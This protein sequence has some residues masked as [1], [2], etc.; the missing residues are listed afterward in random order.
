MNCWKKGAV[1]AALIGACLL[2][3]SFETYAV[4]N[5]NSIHLSGRVPGGSIEPFEMLCKDFATLSPEVRL[6]TASWLDGYASPDNGA[7]MFIPGDAKDFLKELSKV[8]AAN[9][10][11]VIN[12]V[13]ETVQYGNSS[14]PVPPRCVYLNTLESETQ[15]GLL[16][17]WA[18][19]YVINGDENAPD[20]INFDELSTVAN[21]IINQC[22]AAPTA[23][24]LELVEKELN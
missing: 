23:N 4:D 8:C 24:V 16:I 15:A 21:A 18:M 17:A 14:E 7:G 12:D 5:I 13:I 19:G 9:P 3:P 11:K 2:A 6:F 1:I 10:D 22:K 20:V